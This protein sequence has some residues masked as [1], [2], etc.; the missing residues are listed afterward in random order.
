M[1]QN[2]ECLY[3]SAMVVVAAWN[4]EY[5]IGRTIA[6]LQRYLDYSRILVVDGNSRDNT[7]H[8]AKS[9][10]ADVIYQEGGGKGDA[11]R[12]GLKYV[13]SD[14]DYIVFIDADYT[15]PAEFLP[16]MIKILDEKPKVGMVCGNRFNSHYNL[17][18]MRNMLYF[19]N[20]IITVA[21]NLLNGTQ[22]RDPLTGL[23]VVRWDILKD[24]NPK[25]QG[26]DIEVELNHYV[27]SKNYSIAEVP[28]YYRVRVG[29]K[30]LKPKHGLVILKRIMTE[31]FLPTGSKDFPLK[32]QAFLDEFQ[33]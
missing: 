7:V 9:L 24:W 3:P 2:G 28:I 1:A 8:I 13:N 32:L 17:K 31:G 23:R 16:Q 4:E 26:F 30:K 6:E 18:S 22:M 20:V 19:G 14:V 10:G 11:I 15:Y 27:E 25:S 21:H 12:C 33:R 29:E 5:G